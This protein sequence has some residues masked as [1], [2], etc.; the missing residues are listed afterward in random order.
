MSKSIK[1]KNCGHVLEY[2]EHAAFGEDRPEW[3]HKSMLHDDNC[4]CGNP[5]PDIKKLLRN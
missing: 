4:E 5:T 1:C 3:S 2:R